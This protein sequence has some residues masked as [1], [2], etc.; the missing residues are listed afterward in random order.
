MVASELRNTINDK[1]NEEGIV[2]A[3]PQRDVHLNAVG[4]L[5]INIRSMN[6][7]AAE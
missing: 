4:P 3:F 2:I 5:D 7:L 6:D 1:F